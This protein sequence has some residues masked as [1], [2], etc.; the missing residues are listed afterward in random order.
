METFLKVVGGVLVLV[1]FCCMLCWV[2]SIEST[3]KITA[4]V[5]TVNND[6]VEIYDF[7]NHH[8]FEID[9]KLDLRVG[10]KVDVKVSTNG[11]DVPSDDTIL[12]V[13]GKVVKGKRINIGYY[14]N[15]GDPYKP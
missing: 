12:K 2:G 8:W 15:W 10:D 5:M 1:A 9:G 14:E 6:S 11:N 7:D 13:N 4:T 3:E